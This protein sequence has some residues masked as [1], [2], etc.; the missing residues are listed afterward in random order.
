MKLTLALVATLVNSQRGVN[1]DASV[2]EIKRFSQLM[3]LLTHFNPDFDNR[4]Y[5]T[6]GC[7][8]QLLGDMPLS[9]PG[10]G[11]PVDELDS[12]CK[13]YKDCLK[14]ARREFGD[15]CLAEFVRY[16]FSVTDDQVQ[17]EDQAGSCHKAICACDRQFAEAH[18]QALHVFNDDFHM[19]LG[20]WDPS[21]QCLRNVGGPVS[22]DSQCCA[23]TNHAFVSTVVN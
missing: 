21:S 16:D 23:D 15:G 19:F 20:G 6:Y 2:P 7:N 3:A 11:K 12:V 8:C 18:K 10:L 13:T 17:C 5:L 1:S 9:Q 14:C 22:I 4:K